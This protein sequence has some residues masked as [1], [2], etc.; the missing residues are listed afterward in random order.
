MNLLESQNAFV[1]TLLHEHKPQNTL[2]LGLG[3]LDLTLSVCQTLNAID[4]AALILITPNIAQHSRF[5]IEFNKLKEGFL[6][7]LV[8]LI[9]T[10]ADEVLPDFYFQNRSIDFAIINESAPFEQALVAFYYVDKMLA[11]RGTIVIND[12]DTPVMRKLCRYL[13]TERDYTV[14]NTLNSVSKGPLISRLLRNQ[15]NKAPD[16]LKDKIKMFVN[17]ELLLTD[18]DLGL[19]CSSIALT[20]PAA[21]GEIELDFDSLLESIINE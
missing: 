17:A 4:N 10:P 11:S 8:E 9:R 12:V 20:K 3:N 13:I 7:D 18:E 15:F 5:S 6:T 16:F 2:Q 1:T 19:Q 14:Q 21:E